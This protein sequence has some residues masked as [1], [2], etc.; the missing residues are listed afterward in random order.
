MSYSSYCLIYYFVAVIWWV[1][2]S[3]KST[4]IGHRRMFLTL[5]S[6][7]EK[8]HVIFTFSQK[9]LR[10]REKSIVFICVVS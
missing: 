1:N 7:D 4:V 2:V 8:Y 5:S 10:P 6:L 9:P 3:C